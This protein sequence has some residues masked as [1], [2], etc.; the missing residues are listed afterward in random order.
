MEYSYTQPQKNKV[1]HFVIRR[2]VELMTTMRSEA[3]CVRNSYVRDVYEYFLN[4]EESHECEEAEKIDPSYIRE[5]EK[6]QLNAIG[7]KRAEELSV[8]Y[9]A[10]PEPINDFKEFT[11][12]GVLPENIWAFEIKKSVYSQALASL[13]LNE[14]KQPKI[15]KTSIENFFENTP[16]KFDIV[17]IDA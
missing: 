2:A 17:Y 15:I 1:R 9:L 8:C 16:R 10:G 5:R 11:E 4:K 6:L 13:Q 3:C 7:M 12:M 14:F